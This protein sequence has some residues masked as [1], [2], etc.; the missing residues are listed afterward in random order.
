MRPQLATIC[1]ISPGHL[2]TNP[3]LVKEAD[4]LLEAGHRVHVVCGDF[5][6]WAR[7]ADEEFS[8]RR[9][10]SVTAVRF[11][12][13]TP[14]SHRALQVIRYRAARQLLRA[15]VK[16]QATVEAAWHQ[17]TPDLVRAATSIR[18]DLY[19]AH[20]V[21]ALP[22][23]AQAARV[24]GARYA[25]DAE[26]FHLGDP[27]DGPEFDG[28]R[29]HTRAIESAYLPGA[30]YVTAASPGIADAYASAYGI[31]AP[32]VVL[33]VFPRSRAPAAPSER[34]SAA[35]GPSVYW[36]SQTIGSDRGL[37]C[38]VRAIAL[39]RSRPHLYLRGNPE[40]E[41]V[42]RLLALAREAGV[43]DH[44]HLLQPE[45]PAEMERLASQYDVGFVGETGSTANRR[46][47]L[48]NNLFT[49]VL[50][51]IPTIASDIPAHRQMAQ[52]L[53]PAL[54]I[55]PVESAE[56]LAAAFDELLG[57]DGPPWPGRAR[58]RTPSASSRSTGT[59]RRL[60][61]SA[62]SRRS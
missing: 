49:Y 62:R 48:T 6:P 57:D 2:S 38:A 45:R 20:Y 11:G 5:L 9:W 46:I 21:A 31:P 51:G 12:P 8:T 33:N 28:V 17:V 24:H 59:W 22:A 10:T 37:E 1:L 4:G 14:L 19:V 60:S 32:T 43:G 7:A 36:F 35:P 42:S 40:A 27:P 25:F 23:A 47:A 15:G 39:A 34:G 54:R 30:A 53:G 41:F 13:G 50:A 29:R 18:A 56:G 16:A 3:R 58:M 61:W 26:D 55:Y 52:R 44:L